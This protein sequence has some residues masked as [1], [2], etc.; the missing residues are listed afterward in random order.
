MSRA[1]VKESDG[2]AADDL[3]ERAE[4]ANPNYVTEQGLAELRLQ[5]AEALAE[6]DRLSEASNELAVRAPLARLS[7]D[8]RYLQRRI[9]DAIVIEKTAP[10]DEV[11]IGSSVT[12]DDGERQTAFTIVGEDQAD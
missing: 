9:D 7:R 3:P 12:I 6:R 1:F 2:D 10:E 8:I 5:L 4:S 11:A